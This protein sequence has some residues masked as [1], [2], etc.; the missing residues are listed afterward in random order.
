MRTS[1]CQAGSICRWIPVLQAE[2]T[3]AD[4]RRGV[5]YSYSQY[6]VYL[7]KLAHHKHYWMHEIQNIKRMHVEKVVIL[8]QK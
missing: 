1:L 4:R 7:A 3:L 2:R 8:D 6:D 5:N